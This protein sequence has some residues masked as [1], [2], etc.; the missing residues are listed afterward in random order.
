MIIFQQRWLGWRSKSGATVSFVI[1]AKVSPGAEIEDSAL[2]KVLAGRGLGV[3]PV[4]SA[5]ADDAMKQYN[6]RMLGEIRAARLQFFAITVERR[7]QHPLLAT[8][9]QDTFGWT[10]R[11]NAK[12]GRAHV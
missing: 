3:V 5:V 10:Y 6:L 12:I 1:S 2:I 8:L 11:L 9:L 7:F 4:A